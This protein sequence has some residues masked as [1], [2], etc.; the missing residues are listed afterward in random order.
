MKYLRPASPDNPFIARPR[1]GL[2]FKRGEHASRRDP[3]SRDR[4][5]G[6]LIN[7]LAI[8]ID[9][10]SP[11]LQRKAGISA[12]WH[13]NIGFFSTGSKREPRRGRGRGDASERYIGVP[14][15]PIPQE[16]A[17]SRWFLHKGERNDGTRPLYARHVL[18]KQNLC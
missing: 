18:F 5:G 13:G 10:K 11:G 4:G 9:R 2:L 15:V 7:L 16:N 17:L 6:P 14:V 12:R 3:K 8:P 1:H